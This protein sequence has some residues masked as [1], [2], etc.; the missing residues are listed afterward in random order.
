MSGNGLRSELKMKRLTTSGKSSDSEKAL[1]E[2][3]KLLEI[4]DELREKCPWDRDQ[5]LES[6][7]KLTIEETYE[8][9]CH[10]SE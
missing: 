6:L 4:M 9:G 5:T 7:R 1:A 3:R 8:L 2:F 10:P